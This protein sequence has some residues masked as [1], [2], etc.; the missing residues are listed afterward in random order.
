[1]GLVFAYF[2]VVTA[3]GLLAFDF[4]FVAI[5]AGILGLIYGA[6]FGLVYYWMSSAQKAEPE[7]STL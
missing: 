1:L 4:V 5:Y 2:I 6:A 3:K 7:P